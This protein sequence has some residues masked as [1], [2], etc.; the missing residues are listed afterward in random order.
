MNMNYNSATLTLV[1][2]TSFLLKSS[3]D[4]PNRLCN[5][6]F[7]IEKPKTTF[8]SKENK[9]LKLIFCNNG[10]DPISIPEYFSEGEYFGQFGADIV[11]EIKFKEP[12]KNKYY[13]LPYYLEYSRL[14]IE[15]KSIT[16][17]PKKNQH[18]NQSMFLYKC[19]NKIG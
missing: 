6:S 5:I 9:Y 11:F 13:P 12:K 14:E 7:K 4:S 8:Q 1:F 16:L 3:S 17:M 2:L 10:R 19:L 18:I 15:K